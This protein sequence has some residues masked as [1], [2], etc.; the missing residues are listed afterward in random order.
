MR[1]LLGLPVVAVMLAAL[2]ADTADASYC[3]VAKFRRCKPVCCV[4]HTCCKW[5]CHTVMKT[6]R[7]VVYEPK[8]FTCY[9]TCYQPVCVPKTITCTKY[10][11][12]T[13]YRECKFTVCK[14]VWETKTRQ[15]RYT[16]CKPVW[17]TKTRQVC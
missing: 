4:D 8:Q 5:Q 2:S 6:C 7:Q 3:G 15:V 9:K 17:E 14:P 16:V 11:P 10:V 1:A 12:E 13:H